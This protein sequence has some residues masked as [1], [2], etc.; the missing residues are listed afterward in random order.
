MDGCTTWATGGRAE[1]ES[2]L[3]EIDRMSKVRVALDGGYNQ[4]AFLMQQ[5]PKQ[6]VG[7]EDEQSLR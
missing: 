2:V 4:T 3:G 6:D 5:L 1:L 7:L